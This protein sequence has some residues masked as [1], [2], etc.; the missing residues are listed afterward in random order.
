MPFRKNL[1]ISDWNDLGSFYSLRVLNPV[2]MKK[3]LAASLIAFFHIAIVAPLLAQDKP[4]FA[5]ILYIKVNQGNVEPYQKIV[6]ENLK[7]A[8]QLA[9]ESGVITNW[10]LYSVDFSGSESKYNY[11]AMFYYD[12]W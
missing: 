4:V 11:I 5:R 9:K 8:M 2:A 6:V 3:I 12:S 1:P 10:A 7:P